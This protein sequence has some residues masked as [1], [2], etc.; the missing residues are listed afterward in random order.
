MLYHGFLVMGAGT[1]IPTRSGF[2]LWW[3]EGEGNYNARKEAKF[4]ETNSQ[5]G[6]VLSGMRAL[7]ADVINLSVFIPR[8]KCDVYTTIV[9]VHAHLKTSFLSEDSSFPV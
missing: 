8:P 2:G 7:R 3:W 4:S 9:V 5:V 1:K 6:E